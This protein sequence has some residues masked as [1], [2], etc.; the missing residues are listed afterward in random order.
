MITVIPDLLNTEE[1]SAFHQAL[2][3]ADWVSG[4]ETA[5]HIAAQVKSNQQ[6]PL[7]H[8]MAQQLGERMLAALSQCPA[9]IA[10]TLPARI[11]PPRFNQYQAGGAYGNHI[12]NAVFAIP[13][14]SERLRSDV[15]A[16]LFLSHP[17]EYEGG[18][19]VIE[20]TYGTQSV[21][22]PAG[23]LVVYPANSVHRVNPVARGVRL[24]SY[25]WVQ[26]LVREDHKRRLLLELDQSI[27]ALTMQSADAQT[28]S[29]LTGVY[30]NL[31]RE[32]SN[33]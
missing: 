30:H 21:K 27:Q 26:S 29:R 17:D 16:T 1:V 18:E 20:D 4:G 8:P 7:G 9:F 31:I 24:A 14:S 19:L 6:L 3:S 25:F 22:L 23:H 5:G 33:P 15:S 28:I 10:A 13:G 12:D 2:S 11:L 32:W